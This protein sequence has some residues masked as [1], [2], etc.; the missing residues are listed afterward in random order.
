MF[1][2]NIKKKIVNT[3]KFANHDINKFN[4]FLRKGVYPYE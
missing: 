1:D 2:E 4:L 3:Y